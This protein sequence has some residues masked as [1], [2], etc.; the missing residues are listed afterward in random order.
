[1][2]P[3]NSY[4]QIADDPQVIA[5]DLLVDF[6]HEVHTG[7]KMVG[8]AIQLS[9]SPGRIERPAPE[10]GQHTE[11]VLLEFGFDWDDIARLKESGAIG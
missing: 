11:E 2:G 4:D 5:N 9:D 6:P 7:L 10:Y 8:P 3:V 1:M